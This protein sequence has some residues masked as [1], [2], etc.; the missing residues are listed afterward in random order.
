MMLLNEYQ[1]DTTILEKTLA[2]ALL[3]TSDSDGE[4]EE[5]KKANSFNE[6]LT[7]YCEIPEANP[8]YNRVLKYIDEY[9]LQ[10]GKLKNL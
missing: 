6:I 5:I 3:F 4:W 2:G 10:K 8:I 1:L 9:Q 7:K